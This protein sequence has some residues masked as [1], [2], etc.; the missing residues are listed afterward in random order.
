MMIHDGEIRRKLIN[1]EKTLK[2]WLIVSLIVSLYAAVAV[3]ELH[4][5]KW[6]LALPLIGGLIVLSMILENYIIQFWL[7]RRDI[8][9]VTDCL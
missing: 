8:K 9:K 1:D 3:F 2:D 6:Y 7:I 5:D 4:F